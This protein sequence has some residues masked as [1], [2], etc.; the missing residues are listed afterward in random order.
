MGLSAYALPGSRLDAARGPFSFAIELFGKL[1]F[2][3]FYRRFGVAA[4]VEREFVAGAAIAVG[5]Q[6]S[7]WKI[8]VRESTQI[9]GIDNAV[10]RVYPQDLPDE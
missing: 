4:V 3:E 6:P 2:T 1:P 7:D 8:G 10:A 5:V 9:G